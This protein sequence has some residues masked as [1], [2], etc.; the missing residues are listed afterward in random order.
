MDNLYEILFF[1]F[2]FILS[3]LSSYFEKKKKSGQAKK[4]APAQPQKAPSQDILEQILGYKQTE[5]E[6]TAGT[7]ITETETW[8]PEEE[9]DTSYEETVEP[10]RPG[11]ETET[12]R[13]TPPVEAQ[14]VSGSNEEKYK[15]ITGLQTGYRKNIVEKLRNPE[16]LREMVLVSEIL[17]KPKALR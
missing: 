6:P 1:I 2:I 13:Q 14:L 17:G 9:F 3:G 5:P 7:E 8:N 16:T 12:V 10:Y 11:K 15:T 4:K